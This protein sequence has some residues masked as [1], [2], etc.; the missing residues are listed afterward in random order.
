MRKSFSFSFFSSA[1][2]APFSSFRFLYFLLVSKPLITFLYPST[3]SSSPQNKGVKEQPSVLICGQL[4]PTNKK[5]YSL[6]GC[7]LTQTPRCMHHS[8]PWHHHDLSAYPQCTTTSFVTET[9]VAINNTIDGNL[10]CDYSNRGTWKRLRFVSI[11]S[12]YND[13]FCYRNKGSN[14]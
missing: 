12:M 13:V 2:F 4:F 3:L 6:F 10:R 14:K 9:K 8:P 11:S 7:P 5:H 1:D